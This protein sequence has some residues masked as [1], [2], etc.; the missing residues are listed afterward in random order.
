MKK[1]LVLNDFVSWGK[2]AG[3][4]MNTILSYKS[5]DVFFLPTAL[6]SNMFSLKEKAILDSTD[7]IKNSLEAWDKLNIKFDAIFIGFILNECQKDLI[8]NYIKSLKYEP[9][10]FI[11]PIMG[12]SGCLYSSV[13]KN[14]IDYYKEL[15]TF[16]TVI[17]PN[18]TEAR[19]LSGSNINDIHSLIEELSKNNLKLVITSVEIEDSHYIFF[20][21]D[22]LE[23]ISFEYINKSFA[24]TGDIFDG[25]FISY[26]LESF[27]FKYSV[28]K[29]N[30]I[31]SNILRE[32]INSNKSDINIENYL[33]LI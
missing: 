24:G 27:D 21:D 33:Y 3:S 28:A 18:Y 17:L 5:Y 30:N 22:S 1:I 13:D 4:Q 6:I 26:Y 9:I 8:L 15:I 20:K 31:L 10:I 16:A 19:L 25:I 11:D 7:Y 23:K 12:D 14:I 32:N 2:I 29:T